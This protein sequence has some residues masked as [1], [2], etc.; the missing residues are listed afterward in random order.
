MEPLH[1]EDWSG[2]NIGMESWH[3]LPAEEDPSHFLGHTSTLHETS[4]QHSV[5]LDID[6]QPSTREDSGTQQ[7]SLQLEFQD[8]RLSP[9][10]TL[11]PQGKTLSESTLL[12][13]TDSEFVPL[14]EYPDLSVAFVSYPHVSRLDESSLPN[15]SLEEASLS[16]H[17][18]RETVAISEECSS[19]S[20]L[21]Q[22]SLSPSMHYQATQVHNAEQRTGMKDSNER[23]ME[24]KEQNNADLHP[25]MDTL[26]A[27]SSGAPACSLPE[28]LDNNVGVVSSNAV[29]SASETALSQPL[30]HTVKIQ[31]HSSQKESENI[32]ISHYQAPDYSSSEEPKSRPSGSREQPQGGS[33]SS[34]S[35]KKTTGF[36]GLPLSSDLSV[37]SNITFRATTMQP[38]QNTGLPHKMLLSYS[39]NDST[40]SAPSQK[41]A[42]DTPSARFFTPVSG[43]GVCLP[44]LQRVLWGSACQT[45]AD[46]S[47][48]T[49]HPVSQSTPAVLLSREK[50]VMI[51]NS[52]VYSHPDNLATMAMSAQNM[53]SVLKLSTTENQTIPVS[54]ITSSDVIKASDNHEAPATKPPASA[55]EDTSHPPNSDA[56][57]SPSNS[58][59]YTTL[60]TG[61]VSSLPSLSYVQKV[62]AWKANQSSSRSFC[63][64]LS[65]KVFDSI[66]QRK[67]MQDSVSDEQNT[68]MTQQSP[69]PNRKPS[70]FLSDTNAQASQIDAA[71]TSRS[72]SPK[73][74]DV[75]RPG[76]T[77]AAPSASTLAH[78]HSH[79]SLSTVVTFIQPD[80]VQQNL[81]LPRSSFE[82]IT[83]YLSPLL[84][85]G[86][87]QDLEDQPE[88]G[89]KKSSTL[90]SLGQFSDVSSN[91]N[92]INALA[93]SQ[94]S[95]HYKQSLL[96]SVGAASSVVS[97]EVDNY[98]PYWT[99]RPGS[100]PRSFEFSIEDRI[101][102]YLHNL[103]I[104]Q[105]PSTI[106]NP[107]THRGP[108]REPEFSPTDLCTIKGSVGT[109]TK[110]TQPSEGGSPQKETFSSSSLLSVDSS[111]SLSRRIAVQN[112]ERPASSGSVRMVGCQVETV[113]DP[114]TASQPCPASWDLGVS[115]QEGSYGLPAQLSPRSGSHPGAWMETKD[116]DSSLV[117]SGTLQEI[118]CLLGRAESLASVH[119]S[120][121]S[122]PGSHC[123]SE[124]NASFISLR[125]NTQ[126]CLDDSTLSVGGQTS[127]VLARS[128]SDSALKQSSSSSCGLLQL[129]IHNDHVTTEANNFTQR[130]N[131]NLTSDHSAPKRTEPE[132]CNSA[133]P[134]KLGP[135]SLSLM[136]GNA[137]SVSDDHQQI[138]ESA[139]NTG[140]ISPEYSP[141]H[142]QTEADTEVAVSSDSSSESSLAARVAKLL[143]SE[144]PVSVVTSRPST[145]DPEES[146]AREWIMMKVSG[147]RCDSLELKVEDRRRIEEIKRELLLHTKYSKWSSDS[148]GSVQSSVGAVPKPKGGFEAV[149]NAENHLSEQHTTLYQN[150]EN[151][152]RQTTIQE[153][154]NSPAPLASIDTAP[155]RTLSP[156][157]VTN[158]L[159]AKDDQMQS[160]PQEHN[161]AH[162]VLKSADEEKIHIPISDTEIKGNG[163]V[164]EDK[165]NGGNER[166]SKEADWTV[167]PDVANEN[168]TGKEDLPPSV[169]SNLPPFHKSEMPH[170]HLSLS[171]KPEQNITQKL[172]SP[173]NNA[174]SALELQTDLQAHY[175]LRGV[176]PSVSSSSEV[177]CASQISKTVKGKERDVGQVSYTGTLSGYS[178]IN[179]RYPQA[180][181]PQRLR[182][183]VRPLSVLTAV[184]T[185]LP[186]KPHGSSELFY[187]PKSDHD[188]SPGR[189]DTTVES[190][191][192]G[193]DDAVPPPFTTE[194][195]GCR[196]LEDNNI[197]PKHKEGIYS[198]RTKM[199][200]ESNGLGRDLLDSK[201]AQ[202]GKAISHNHLP[203]FSIS[204]CPDNDRGGK[205]NTEEEEEF[206][207]LHMEAD[208]STDDLHHQRHSVRKCDLVP[209]TPIRPIREKEQDGQTQE[210]SME[211]GSSLDQLW[212]RFNE[213]WSLQESQPTKEGETSLL[214]RLERLSRLLQSSTP[215]ITPAKQSHSRE[216]RSKSRKR[217]LELKKA[218]GKETSRRGVDTDKHEA[219]DTA[220]K[221]W[222]EGR[223]DRTLQAEEQENTIHCPA[224]RDES[225]SVSAETGSSRS[226][227]DTH[228]LLRAFGSHRV[229]SGSA[230]ITRGQTPKSGGSLLK[231]YNTINKQK[232]GHGSSI[233][234]HHFTSA[235]TE[236][237]STD[238]TMESADSLS[239]SSTYTLPSQ[240]GKTRTFSTKKP[241]VKLVSRGI[242]AGDLEIVVN[243]TRKHTRDV[244]TTF[245]S[246]CNARGT[247]EPAA[248]TE[249]QTIISK[250]VSSS[251]VHPQTVRRREGL[252]KSNQT[253]YPNG[254]SWFVSADELKLDAHK[255]NEPQTEAVQAINHAWFEPCIKTWPWR[256]PLR[257]PLRERHIQLQREKLVVPKVPAETNGNNPTSLI[258]LSLQEALEL[259]RPLFVSRSR[260]R[261]K[262]LCLL[263]EE[264]KLQA[265]F[266]REREELFNRPLP[267]H[268]PKAVP[269]LL[270]SKRV[271]P[272]KEMVERSKSWVEEKAHILTIDKTEKVRRIFAQLPEV[273]KRKQEEKRKAE[274]R[275]YRLNAQLFN[276]KVTNKVLGRRAP[277]Q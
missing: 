25:G 156:Q 142:S 255:E 49:S 250:S 217:D 73:I 247:R 231:L 129:S 169:D 103:G 186:Y 135:V 54:N 195:L 271:I 218:Q 38:D 233:S 177:R 94:D 6:G 261:M 76:G 221:A 242:Q 70:E 163:T 104:D 172:H 67:K 157:P 105:S 4:C 230:E 91:P 14:R 220:Q 266:N 20:S 155:T 128:S 236:V 251:A 109:P 176:P 274:Y 72:S 170:S 246:P 257:E 210:I 122:S 121:D 96:A 224:E 48:L 106:L 51:K 136:Q 84:S 229:N 238:E 66:P 86:A 168:L 64:N 85:K 204:S 83:P 11:I 69:Y 190:S 222:E 37:T 41:E 152:V 150:L 101:P 34:S 77:E 182:G 159:T 162:T 179:S 243:G 29:S 232:G 240:R 175:P 202:K 139:E 275:T 166:Q 268:E 93:S 50:P 127:L 167:V 264:R 112:A 249:I 12:H 183:P 120:L 256:E 133:D 68:M 10:L 44:G 260:E 82:E 191:H 24:G 130:N 131:K 165:V 173:A 22:H 208:Y 26:C 138:Q 143:Q 215:P 124:S 259:H 40:S 95:C 203:A 235:A 115:Q 178:H 199:N 187:M 174:Y 88:I 234:E 13:Q 110:S 58:F 117:G 149:R 147:H 99:S 205:H 269:P 262:R 61:R 55:A 253:C 107:F 164:S 39:N 254:V 219:R 160:A 19:C 188:L 185:L 209:E 116:E 15:I 237:I 42:K 33:S 140:I 28:H 35:K 45:A 126:T 148:E 74:R 43:V 270:P 79:S 2:H 216:D 92:I 200:R 53:I 81:Q 78:S 154:L 241:K 71:I 111:A 272:V 212:H 248:S 108:I 225:T 47:F 23:Q 75:L 3:Q 7:E 65:L 277:W 97:L 62:D 273:Q 119:S 223:V 213:R 245:P 211:I 125:Q 134:D 114:H 60:S 151:R 18:F 194:V 207:P 153:L 193:S 206:A 258:C 80:G 16:Q 228:R 171:T 132:G 244:G 1:E 52:P 184:P 32:D 27:L 161:P 226:T 17:H 252:H 59:K 5:P 263:A 113:P 56:L 63:D 227:I 146:R 98:A 201:F 197:T 214:E 239:S 198:K 141:T 189:S 46:G 276:K 57:P 192:P 89:P 100:P 8:S 158:C 267:H 118:R 144:S 137:L 265:V 123:F 21:S 87:D 36:I 181:P 180:F 9:A 31:P 145:T 90:L 196:E 30:S 102:L